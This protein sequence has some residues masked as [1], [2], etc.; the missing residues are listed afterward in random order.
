MCKQLASFAFC[1]I[2]Q[3]IRRQ[4]IRFF[5]LT[6]G[7]RRKRGNAREAHMRLTRW[8]GTLLALLAMASTAAAEEAWPS[9]RVTLVVPFGAGSST[10]VLARYLADNFHKSFGQPFIVENRGGAGSTLGAN[11]VAKATSDGYTLLMG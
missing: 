10:D 3:L 9:R 11:A 8:L 2:G 5:L 1:V 7:E 6:V 4:V